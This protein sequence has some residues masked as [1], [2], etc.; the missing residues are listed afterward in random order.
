MAPTAFR[1]QNAKNTSGPEKVVLLK[2]CTQLW[3]QAHFEVNMLKA[4]QL[5]SAFGSCI[6]PQKHAAVNPSTCR[7]QNVT[8]TSV[9]ECLWNLWC[10]K[11]CTRLWGKAHFEVNIFKPHCARPTFGRS[12]VIFCGTHNGFCTSTKGSRM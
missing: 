3:C 7:S 10:S 5:R 2:K 11:K 6:A 12:R 4:P 9:S 8:S 1:S